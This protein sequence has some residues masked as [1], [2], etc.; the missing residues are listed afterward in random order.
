[1]SNMITFE[2]KGMRELDA[3]LKRF[4]IDMQR[5][6][7]EKSLKAGS[8]IVQTHG[9]QNAR[10]WKRRTGEFFGGIVI[11]KLRAAMPTY[12][13]GVF[14]RGWFGRLLETGWTATGPRGNK[15]ILLTGHLQVQTFRTDAK[16]WRDWR[17]GRQRGK[18]RVEGHPW[19]EPALDRNQYRIVDAM[20][21]ELRKYLAKY[22]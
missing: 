8:K 6:A 16:T 2:V 15:G 19:L 13:V 1:M 18:S 14:K 10:H 20:A 11:R 5:D 21:D 3:A 22:R 4:P 9:R 17:S 7:V 12:G